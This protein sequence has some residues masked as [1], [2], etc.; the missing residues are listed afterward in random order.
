MDLSPE[1]SADVISNAKF[2]EKTGARIQDLEMQ[3]SVA[4]ADR[5]KI[6]SNQ[7]NRLK[8]TYLWRLLGAVAGA[9]S[10]K[11]EIVSEKVVAIVENFMGT[12]KPKFA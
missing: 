5:A 9:G 6:L 12:N 1:S 8:L 11:L 7:A 10:I 4:G 3:S 2:L